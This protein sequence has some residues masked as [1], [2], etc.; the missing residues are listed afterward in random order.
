[1]AEELSLNMFLQVGFE[2]DT[3]YEE[4]EEKEEERERKRK[5]KK[6]K[7]YF[8]INVYVCFGNVP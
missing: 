1:M 4:E 7:K 3:L 5:K 6:R 2:H 8:C